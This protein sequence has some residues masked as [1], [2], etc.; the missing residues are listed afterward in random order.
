MFW[1]L[2]LK[3]KLIVFPRVLKHEQKQGKNIIKDYVLV[4]VTD[5]EIYTM[6]KKA[7]GRA[8]LMV[9]ELGMA[10][11]FVKHLFWDPDVKIPGIDGGAENRFELNDDESDSDELSDEDEPT[12]DKEVS[13]KKVGQ[14]QS[15]QDCVVQWQEMCIEDVAVLANDYTDRLF[16]VRHKQ[17]YSSDIYCCTNTSSTST[18]ASTTSTSSI[19][20][21]TTEITITKLY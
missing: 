2:K 9:E 7:Q 1:K 10:D 15:E 6:I 14:E 3:R 4:D 18:N 16:R 5:D 8:K 17:P 20:M 19:S 13:S 11:V 12:V 21:I